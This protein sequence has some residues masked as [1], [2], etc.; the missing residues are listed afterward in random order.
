MSSLRSLELLYCPP[1]LRISL[2][3]GLLVKTSAPAVLD[4]DSL[5]VDWKLVG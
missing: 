5:A 3:L 4:G 1:S 2:G